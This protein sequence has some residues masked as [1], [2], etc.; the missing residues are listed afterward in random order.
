[1]FRQN[2]K[3]IPMLEI[4]GF[5]KMQTV[6]GPSVSVLLTLGSVDEPPSADMRQYK[7]FC[8]Q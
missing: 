8:M 4:L 1:M 3:R 2:W 7:Q 6:N 5:A